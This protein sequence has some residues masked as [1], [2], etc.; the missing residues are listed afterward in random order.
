MFAAAEK[1]GVLHYLNHNYRRVPAVAFAKRLIEEGKIGQIY[2]WRGAYLQD[3]IIDPDFPL[4]WQLRK[5]SAG[6]GPQ[7]DLELPQR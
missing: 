1:A 5:E 3:W 6:A 7:F 2:H 4:T